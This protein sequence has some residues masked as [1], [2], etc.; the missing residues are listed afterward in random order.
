MT[1]MAVKINRERTGRTNFFI[2]IEGI[3]LQ[4]R[5]SVGRA[6]RKNQPYQVEW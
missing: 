1:V 5:G 4:R 6:I 3:W 2:E